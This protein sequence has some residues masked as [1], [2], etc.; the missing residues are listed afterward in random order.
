VER[1]DLK[2]FGK[3]LLNIAVAII[4]FAII[5]PLIKGNLHPEIVIYSIIVYIIVVIVGMF[6]IRKGGKKDDNE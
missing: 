4:V 6:F 2:E 5:Q 1:E 3:H